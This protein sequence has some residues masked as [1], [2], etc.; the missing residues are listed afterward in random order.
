[1]LS[2]LWRCLCGPSDPGPVRLKD[3][4]Q[5]VLDTNKMGELLI[6]CSLRVGFGG[7]VWCKDTNGSGHAIAEL[8][9]GRLIVQVVLHQRREGLSGKSCRRGVV[10]SPALLQISNCSAGN[11]PSRNHHWVQFTHVQ[12]AVKLCNLI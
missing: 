1:M 10:L 3:V 4:Q 6:L 5:V 9:V 8:R 11:Y 12:S 7:S 2:C